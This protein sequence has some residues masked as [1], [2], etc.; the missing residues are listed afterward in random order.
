MRTRVLPELLRDTHIG[1]II[2]AQFIA[3]ALQAT[4]RVIEEPLVWALFQIINWFSFKAVR[5]NFTTYDERLDCVPMLGWIMNAAVL[6]A[7]AYLI[8][9][10][11][12]TPRK[13]VEQ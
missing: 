13:R 9:A 5:G 2:V 11:V 3:A 10:W 8:A 12:Y 6:L 4:L 1:A 7:V